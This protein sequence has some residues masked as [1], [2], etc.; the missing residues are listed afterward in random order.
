MIDR[1]SSGSTVHC[2]ASGVAAWRRCA[3]A[4]AAASVPPPKAAAASAAASVASVP[5]SAV[6]AASA[7]ASVISVPVSVVAAASVVTSPRTAAY[8]HVIVVVVFVRSSVA[9]VRRPVAVSFVPSSASFRRSRCADACVSRLVCE[10]WRERQASHT[11]G[12]ASGRF[13]IPHGLGSAFVCVVCRTHDLG[14][15]VQFARWSQRPDDLNVT[16]LEQTCRRRLSVQCESQ[17]ASRPLRHVDH[18]ARRRERQ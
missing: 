3:A 10:S 6:A 5:V 18:V 2:L 13:V 15:T 1:L 11:I 17:A 16:G 12:C 4:A 8:P 7:A 14:E 9:V